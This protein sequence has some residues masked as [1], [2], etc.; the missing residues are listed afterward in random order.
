MHLKGGIFEP[1]ETTVA[2]QRLDK[3]VS[4]ATDKHAIIEELFNGDSV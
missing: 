1:E 2:R 4:A 3:H